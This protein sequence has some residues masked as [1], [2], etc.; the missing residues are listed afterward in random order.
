MRHFYNIFHKS[1]HTG[2][3]LLDWQKANISPIFQTGNRSD[4]ANCRPVSLTSFPCKMLGY[5][6]HT[7]IMR[8][9]EQYKVLNDEQRGFCRGR[10][11]E[12]DSVI[13][14]IY[15]KTFHARYSRA[16]LTSTN[17]VGRPSTTAQKETSSVRSDNRHPSHFHTTLQHNRSKSAAT[18]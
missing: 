10:S 11:C 15:S 14:Q 8:H 13:G 2:E 17:E 12:T 6:T 7:N 1:L 16:P 3:L 18:Q 5:I 9:L 4:P